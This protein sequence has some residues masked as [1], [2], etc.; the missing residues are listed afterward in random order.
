[1]QMQM[2]SAQQKQTRA[3]MKDR[4]EERMLS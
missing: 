2:A 3:G 4:K 1:M